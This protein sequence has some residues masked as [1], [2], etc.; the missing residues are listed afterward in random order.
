MT[1]ENF[2][3]A[4]ITHLA[5]FSPF[6]LSA[7]PCLPTATFISTYVSWWRDGSLVKSTSCSS[8]G[9]GFCS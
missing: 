3:Q 1:S 7:V 5:M 9:P 8:R 6:L 2:T 4:C